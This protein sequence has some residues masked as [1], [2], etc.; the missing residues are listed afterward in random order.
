MSRA[1]PDLVFNVSFIIQNIDS[2]LLLSQLPFSD[3]EVHAVREALRSV[4]CTYS[5]NVVKNLVHVS[6][7]T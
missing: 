1:S 4:M 5:H 3:V 7:E 6:R 2:I